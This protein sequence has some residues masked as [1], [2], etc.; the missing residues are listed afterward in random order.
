MADDTP[1]DNGYDAELRD[2][3][4]GGGLGLAGKI[5]QQLIALVVGPV[6]AR[7][8][9]VG[10]YGILDLCSRVSEILR[11][12]LALGLPSAISRYVAIYEGEGRRDMTRGAVT[13]T[14]VISALLGLIASAI[15]MLRPEWIAKGIYSKP[16]MA[17]VLRIMIIALPLG[18]CTGIL[19][20]TTIARRTMI[21]RMITDLISR[22]VTLA[23]I[24]VACW[25]LDYG[26]EGA[27]AAMAINSMIIM[28]I[29][30]T[31]VRRLVGRLSWRDLR[32]FEWRRLQFFALPLL[33]SQLAQFGLFRINSLVGG[34]WLTNEELGQ[35]AA[36][37]RLATFG[38]FGV[39]AIGAMFTPIIADLHNRG[40]RTELRDMFQ[41][42]T[43]WGYM[44]T[45]PAILIAVVKA[46]GLLM[47][48][49]P[50][51]PDA[52]DALRVLCVGQVLNVSAGPASL[53]LAMSGYP[54][55]TAAN[56]TVMALLNVLLCVSLT[57]SMRLRGLAM[58]ATIATGGVS[59][60]RA[61][62]ATFILR[63][64][65]YTWR[66]VKPLVAA[67]LACPL[68]FLRFDAWLLDL[69]IPSALFGLAYLL[70]LKLIGLEKDDR[71]ILAQL[72]T[73]LRRD[74]S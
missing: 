65:P 66:A 53:L 44:L 68:L 1:D 35:Y 58:A 11:L 54:W 34:A 12:V 4:K 36:A 42:T 71:F 32:N 57:K 2:V 48:F 21:Y 55:V 14:L 3:A 38:L 51:F 50:D 16:E 39:V 8:L 69:A 49:G 45:L 33:L 10:A 63:I 31:G 60:A 6:T 25:L 43:R 18:M 27:A 22:P 29:F 70:A 62:E 20:P 23:G 26:P 40:K 15:I 24:L 19:A 72:R 56:N 41:T 28:S 61:I 52:T 59:V 46:P 5:G 9:G 47:L 13:G 17:T 30:A 73:K 74:P 67:A 64:T 7:L 37:S